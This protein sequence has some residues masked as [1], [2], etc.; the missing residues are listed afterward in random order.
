MKYMQQQKSPVF[1]P[2]WKFILLSVITL[3]TYTVYWYY[4]TWKFMRDASKEKLSPGWRTFGLAIPIVNIVLLYRFFAG[5]D[6][7]SRLKLHPT[8]MTILSIAAPILGVKFPMVWLLVLVPRWLAQSALNS[9]EKPESLPWKKS[10]ITT[11]TFLTIVLSPIGALLLV[12]GVRTFLISPF[13]FEGNSMMPTI[14]HR[15]YIIF[16]KWTYITD[17]PRRGDI[18]VFRPPTD[19]SKFYVKRIVGLP[20]ETIV[21]R[22]GNVYIRKEGEYIQ[23]QESYLDDFNEGKTFKYPVNSGDK[24]EEAYAIPENQYFVLGDYRQG[25]LDSRSFSH[26]GDAATAFVPR[27]TIIGK[28]V[29]IA[30]PLT[31]DRFLVQPQYSGL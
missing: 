15:D 3:D 13:Q 10:E 25:S 4:K 8:F 22:D 19:P 31:H 21:L 2:I 5:I 18:V 27:T 14:E 23:I 17:N 24:T 26:L 6:R 16:S 28:A 20:R 7:L 29:Y 11:C 9:I 30:L 12:F 1:L